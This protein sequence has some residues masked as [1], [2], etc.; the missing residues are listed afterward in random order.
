MDLL[1]ELPDFLSRDDDGE[2]NVT[3]TRIGLYH[4]VF[5][6]NQGE[7]AESL[8]QRYPHI[9]LASVHKVNAFYLENKVAVD[10]SVTA[11]EAELDRQRAS[12]KYGTSPIC[13]SGS[14]S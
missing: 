8:V 9:P 13:A 3:G 1:I 11:Y 14:T 6:Y 5:D 7:S 10:R 2:I 12:G 4:F